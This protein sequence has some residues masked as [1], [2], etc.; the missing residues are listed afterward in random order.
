MTI[1]ALKAT[2]ADLEPVFPRCYAIWTYIELFW[3]YVIGHMA[4]L[5]VYGP[6]RVFVGLILDPC[7]SFVGS[8]LAA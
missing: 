7:W 6:S 1:L 8:M 4:D 3:R 2:R 5:G